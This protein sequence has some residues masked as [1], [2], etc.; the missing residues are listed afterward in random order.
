MST[1]SDWCEPLDDAVAEGRFL[2]D[3]ALWRPHVLTCPECKRTV[4]GV[5]AVQDYFESR[6]LDAP[7]VEPAPEDSLRVINEVFAR[8]ARRQALKRRGFVGGATA[9]LLGAA[10]WWAWPS[11]GT[12]PTDPWAFARGLRE[13]VAPAG[14]PSR[15]EVLRTDSAERAR[16]VAALEH[17]SSVVRRTALHALLRGGVDL[18]PE[19]LEGILLGWKEDLALPLEVAEGA[20][21]EA[22]HEQALAASADATALAVLRGALDQV[23]RGGRPLRHDVVVPLL[24]YA[25][26]EVR[27]A[28]ISLLRNDPTYR[29]D[30]TLKEVVRSDPA[31]GVRVLAAECLLARGG[32]ADALALVERLRTSPDAAVEPRVAGVLARFPAGVRLAK[33]RIRDPTTSARPW[34]VYATVLRRI[35]EPVPT[36]RLPDLIAR[37]DADDLVTVAA[38]SREA[39][40]ATA[41][42]CLQDRWERLPPSVLRPILAKALA[43]WDLAIGGPEALRRALGICRADTDGSLRDVLEA[44]VASEDAEVRAAARALMAE[45]SK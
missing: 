4:E 14:G 29:P 9:V 36:E 33:D 31:G 8:Y 5:F 38:L 15:Y 13:V 6:A 24:R 11:R 3:P 17:P 41:R 32:E 45:R 22:R 26:P 2:E 37:A 19:R 39:G 1:R 20:G 43:D 25:N 18:P 16:F 23:A 34:A 28:A 44:L 12:E 30:D 40:W 10:V 7:V 21:G 27:K 35:G 42:S